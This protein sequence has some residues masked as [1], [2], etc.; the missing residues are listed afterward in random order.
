MITCYSIN[1]GTC[2]TISLAQFHPVKRYFWI[3]A[4]DPDKTELKRLADLTTIPFENLK[5][6][7]DLDARPRMSDHENYKHIVYKSPV[8]DEKKIKT[9]SFSI[10]IFKNFVLTTRKK[11]FDV[12]ED[13]HGLPTTSKAQLLQSPAKFV[14]KLLD[15]VG[16]KYF[17]IL[18]SIEDQVHEFEEA[19]FSQAKKDLV[20]EI[21]KAKKT[22]VYFHKALTANRDVVTSLEKQFFPNQEVDDN[23]LQNLRHDMTELID[24]VGIYREVMT[25]TLE[26]YL[27]QTSLNLNQIIK[28][29]TAMA[30]FILIPTLI[31]GIYGMNFQY[32]PELHWRY[33][34]L[35]SFGIMV[36]CVMILFVYFKKQQWL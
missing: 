24:L 29:M 34:Y 11:N 32:M 3:D 30:S 16:D 5:E 31:A 6:S 1:K 21:F 2:E 12:F 8:L 27:S 23:L 35:F 25:T 33:G 15:M 7:M 4:W 17:Y 13:I 22:L 26:M 20:K 14:L 36:V 18:D 19:I 10:Y 9:I 28:K